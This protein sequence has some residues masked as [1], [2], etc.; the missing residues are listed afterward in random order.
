M[1]PSHSDT[2]SIGQSVNTLEAAGGGWLIFK[3][4]SVGVWIGVAS[5][6]ILL[7]FVHQFDREFAATNMEN[8]PPSDISQFERFRWTL[9]KTK[10]LRRIRL[11]FF[12]TAFSMIGHVSP[13]EDTA[14]RRQHK[15]PSTRQKTISLV[16]NLMGLFWCSPSKVR[17]CSYSARSQTHK[18]NTGCI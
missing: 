7:I 3:P 12:S 6:I 1:S 9:M 14:R 17:R 8:M 16:G 18:G 11:G 13:G 2:F 10:L 4:F 5:I 15:S